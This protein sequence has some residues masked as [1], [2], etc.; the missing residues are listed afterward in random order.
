[1]SNSK[2]SEQ[3]VSDTVRSLMISTGQGPDIKLP[4]HLE[5]Q[6]YEAYPLMLR[7]FELFARFGLGDMSVSIADVKQARAA[8]YDQ[9]PE[10]MQFV[11]DNRYKDYQ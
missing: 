7:M 6:S 8:V 1:M 2:P 9:Y 10:L 4:P 3:L 11:A 5:Q